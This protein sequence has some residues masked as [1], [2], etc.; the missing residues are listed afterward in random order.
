[1]AFYQ[2]L[3]NPSFENIFTIRNP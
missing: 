1:M 2:V 3:T